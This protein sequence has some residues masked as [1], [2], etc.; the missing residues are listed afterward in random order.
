MAEMSTMG[1][2]RCVSCELFFFFFETFSFSCCDFS[3]N[4]TKKRRRRRRRR[5]LLDE[6]GGPGGYGVTGEAA[7]LGGLLAL[8]AQVEHLDGAVLRAGV[9][10]VACLVQLDLH[11]RVRLAEIEERRH[12]VEEL[13]VRQVDF[14]GLR[15][16]P[17]CLILSKRN[18]QV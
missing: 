18:Y 15:A 14:L 12:Q 5:R 10:H 3:W 11:D 4:M 1:M 9:Q 8:G 17:A 6:T 13:A 2:K 16:E 7:E